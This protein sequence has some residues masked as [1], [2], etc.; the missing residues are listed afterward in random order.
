MFRIQKITTENFIARFY[1]ICKCIS[2]MN[3]SLRSM[4]STARSRTWCFSQL[5]VKIQ[6]RVGLMKMGTAPEEPAGPFGTF[7]VDRNVLCCLFS[8]A[9]PQVLGSDSWW[10]ARFC[11]SKGCGLSC[12]ATRNAQGSVQEA[13]SAFREQGTRLR[14]IRGWFVLT[15]PPMHRFRETLVFGSASRAGV[16]WT[17]LRHP[18]P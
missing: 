1:L 8:C 5:S 14:G 13:W 12:P 10:Q 7:R 9:S 18:T 16:R 17:S 15:D 2:G 11:A 3:L 6:P 4:Y